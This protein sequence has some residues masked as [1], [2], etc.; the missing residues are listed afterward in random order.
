MDKRIGQGPPLILPDDFDTSGLDTTNLLV[1]A[2]ERFSFGAV[3][4]R[5]IFGSFPTS[6]LEP[7]VAD[8]VPFETLPPDKDVWAIIDEFRDQ[9]K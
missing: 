4:F 9:K 5:G 8:P 7:A 2:Y 6:G 3:D 1:H